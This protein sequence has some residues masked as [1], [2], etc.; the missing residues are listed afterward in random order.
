[1]KRGY[2]RSQA[3]ADG[4]RHYFTGRPCKNGHVAERYT[5]NGDC[6]ECHREPTKVKSICLCCGCEFIAR[7]REWSR[8]AQKYCSRPCANQAHRIFRTCQYCGKEYSKYQNKKFCSRKCRG[9]DSRGRQLSDEHVAKLSAAKKG[10][11]QPWLHAPEVR[12]KISDALTGKALPHR[13][14]KNH[15]RFKGIHAGHLFRNY[16]NGQVEYKT[17]K[18]AVLVRD[19][20]TCQCCGDRGG[21]LQAH[22]IRPWAEYPDERLDIDNGTTLCHYCHSFIHSNEFLEQ[23]EGEYE[24]YLDYIKKNS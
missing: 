22:H 16:L 12:Q 11:V 4:K 7:K 5:S 10:K 1:M 8:A 18:I 20:Y 15:W 21:K 13:R 23:V 19:D 2:Q 9:L 17:W 24:N 3:K 6:V 14:G